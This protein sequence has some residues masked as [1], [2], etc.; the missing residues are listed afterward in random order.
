MEV[1][2]QDQESESRRLGPWLELPPSPPRSVWAGGGGAK[3][4]I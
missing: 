1:L 4:P 2:L 3:K